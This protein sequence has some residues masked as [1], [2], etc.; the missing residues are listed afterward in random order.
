MAGMPA[1]NLI[2]RHVDIFVT[3]KKYSIDQICGHL[4]RIGTKNYKI[5]QKKFA[6]KIPKIC[7]KKMKSLCE[8]F[9]WKLP[10][11]KSLATPAM[12]LFYFIVP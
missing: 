11:K 3:W 5:R 6:P 9:Y 2:L 4:L 12:Y 8:I 10:C 7:K 1:S